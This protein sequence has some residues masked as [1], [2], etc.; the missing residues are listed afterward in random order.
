MDPGL[1]LGR[2]G[3]NSATIDYRKVRADFIAFLE[4]RNLNRGYVEK[5]LRYLD[6]YVTVI[7]GPMDVVRVFGGLT[8]G[9]QHNLIRGVRS[10]FN[11]LEAQGFSEGYLNV[12]RKNIPRDSVGVD[13][14]IPSEEEILDSLGRLG[15]APAKYQ[16]LFNLLL[17]SGLR[18]VEAIDLINGFKGAEEVSGFYRCDVGSFRGSKQSYYAHFT[19]RTLKQP[20]QQHEGLK[21]GNVSHYFHK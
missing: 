6:R 20:R 19:H 18:L 5:T 16:A 15:S 14:R 7:E 13:V 21:C 1:E 10:L 17:D 2:L 9:Q 3:G 4:S 8:N 11:F 12:L